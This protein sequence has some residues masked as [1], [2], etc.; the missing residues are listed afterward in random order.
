MMLVVCSGL[1][2]ADFAISFGPAYTNYFVQAKN[3]SQ[4]AGFPGAL[5]ETLKNSKLI[6]LTPKGEVLTQEKVKNLSKE[7]NIILLCGHYEGIDQRVLDKLNVE[8]ISVGDY[9][10]TGGEIPA[11]I[12]IDAVSRNVDGVISKDSLE[13]ES[14]SNSNR[15]VR[16][17][18]IYKTRNI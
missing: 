17:P 7:E 16:I 3:E 10:L 15:N 14:F 5:Q 8:E 18:T 11:M 9:I 13:E 4:F 2:F 6:Y 1:I 12:V